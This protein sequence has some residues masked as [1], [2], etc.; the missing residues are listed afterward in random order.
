MEVKRARELVELAEERAELLK[1]RIT[2]VLRSSTR[3]AVLHGPNCRGLAR[4]LTTVIKLSRPEMDVLYMDADYAHNTLIPYISENL[5]AVLLLSHDARSLVRAATAS[6]LLGVRTLAV[7]Q[8]LS[9]QVRRVLEGVEL[10]ELEAEVLH[11]AALI[12]S[13]RIGASLGSAARV[14]RLQRETVFS[15]VVDEL[16][17]RYAHEVEALREGYTLIASPSMESL[18]EF[19]RVRGLTAFTIAEAGGIKSIERA[20]IAYTS[21]EEHEVTDTV[22]RLRAS[23]KQL[24]T[25]RLNTDPLTAPI[26]G[27]I[28]ALKALSGTK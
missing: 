8:R 16:G 26:Y 4:H 25:L 5:D 1:I 19:L 15:T 13:V 2:E 6:R 17:E 7:T 9:E 23:G 10:I 18:A 27:I 14:E 11:L 21:S 3:I 28:L 22:I 24:K 20:L 12:A